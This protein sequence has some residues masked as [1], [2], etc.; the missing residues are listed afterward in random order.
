MLPDGLDQVDTG[1]D[2]KPSASEGFCDFGLASAIESH[3]SDRLELSG[4]VMSIEHSQ[5]ELA[6]VGKDGNELR[7]IG[8]SILKQVHPAFQVFRFCDL[9]VPFGTGKRLAKVSRFIEGD[10]RQ[11][12][13]ELVSVCWPERAMIER[14]QKIRTEGA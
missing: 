13:P 2:S 14:I 6:L 7:R 8:G 3:Q 1:C 9:R 4:W 11:E 12:T 10:C 5:E